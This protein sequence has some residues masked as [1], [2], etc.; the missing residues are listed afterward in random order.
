MILTAQAIST[1][2]DK[3]GNSRRAF[4]VYLPSGSTLFVKE[5]VGARIDIQRAIGSSHAYGLTAVGIRV[6][7]AEFNRLAKECAPTWDAHLAK[8][9]SRY[10]Q[11]P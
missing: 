8:V 5:T 2:P 7:P 9:A 1:I 11:I 4:L 6:G 10:A 3:N